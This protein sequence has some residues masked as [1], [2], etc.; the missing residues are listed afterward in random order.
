MFYIHIDSGKGEKF[1]SQIF[2]RCSD[3]ISG[4]VDYQESVVDVAAYCDINRSILFVVFFN[5]KQ[6]S[7]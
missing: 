4:V 2:K 7:V 3:V 5:V 1:L 6:E